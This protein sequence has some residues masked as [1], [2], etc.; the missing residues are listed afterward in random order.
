[1][2]P[3]WDGPSVRDMRTRRTL[4]ALTCTALAVGCL[5]ARATAWAGGP[6]SALSAQAE[7]AW[8][9]AS[10]TAYDSDRSSW[11]SLMDAQGRG[12]IFYGGSYRDYRFDTGRLSPPRTL[13]RGDVSLRVSGIGR[14][15]QCATWDGAFGV[16][17]GCRA[18]TAAAWSKV[19]VSRSAYAEAVD[20]AVAA[21]GRSAMVVWAVVTSRKAKIY[22][23]RFTFSNGRLAPAVALSNPVARRLPLTTDLVA[24]GASGFLVAYG[25]QGAQRGRVASTYIQST[26]DGRSWSRRSEVLLAPLG[27]TPA[28]VAFADLSHD[29]TGAVALATQDVSGA[30][31]ADE[32]MLAS[33]QGGRFGAV[34]ELPSMSRPQ[35][36]VVGEIISIVG[37]SPTTP[38]VLL[39]A[40]GTQMAAIV[41][42]PSMPEGAS[43][44]GEFDVVGQ[45]SADGAPG[46]TVT[47][48]YYAYDNDDDQV[49]RLYAA[50]GF[51]DA[52]GA[53]DVSSFL[54]LTPRA[55]YEE[56]M[57]PRLAGFDRYAMVAYAANTEVVF[58]VRSPARM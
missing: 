8:Q 45:T 17:M 9:P 54:E 48:A 24:S 12:T 35:L 28:P 3:D 40:P 18:S 27:G 20:V 46:F 31:E 7:N 30:T 57:G 43:R 29:G 26:T 36:A 51:M 33:F 44:L 41:E 11:A 37:A 58:G 50:S 52:S 5:A 34:D 38:D 47:A 21:D 39:Y 19:N 42:R 55:S 10:E 16:A 6:A 14:G 23:S 56:G 22:A 1:M 15:H 25:K 32:W 49:D 53:W 2:T 13:A 4:S